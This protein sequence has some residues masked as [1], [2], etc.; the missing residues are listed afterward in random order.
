MP[1]PRFPIPGKDA[2]YIVCVDGSPRIQACGEGTIFDPQ[3]L[4]CVYY[5]K[6]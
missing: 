4:T 3:I 1:F 5:N 2:N 6:K